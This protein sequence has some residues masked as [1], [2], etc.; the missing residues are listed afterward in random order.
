MNVK[1]PACAAL[2][3]VPGNVPAGRCFRC[4]RC[5]QPFTFTVAKTDSLAVSTTPPQQVARPSRDAVEDPDRSLRETPRRSGSRG[6]T[7]TP[8]GLV[9]GLA[10]GAFLLLGGALL[11]ALL[12]L[13]PNDSTGSVAQAKPVEKEKRA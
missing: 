12:W 13:S 4:P 2:L 6:R 9:L 5:S 11:G 7:S 8:V 3:A 1:C 10:V